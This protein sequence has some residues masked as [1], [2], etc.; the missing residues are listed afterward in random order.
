[1]SIFRQKK[2]FLGHI[3]RGGQPIVICESDI[4]QSDRSAGKL[5]TP[6]T[7]ST[8]GTPATAA[9]TPTTARMKATAEKPTK[10]G[11]LRQKQ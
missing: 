1:M 5:A 4:R 11:R 9:V 3:S 2:I 7:S 6:K 10:Q 8:A